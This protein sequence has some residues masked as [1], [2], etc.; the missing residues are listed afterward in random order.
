MLQFQQTCVN[1]DLV[2]GLVRETTFRACYT[3]N[4]CNGLCTICGMAV[5]DTSSHAN[6]LQSSC[7]THSVSIEGIIIT[8]TK[9][10]SMLQETLLQATCPPYCLWAVRIKI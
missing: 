2:R 3:L 7:H 1:C 9:H 5:R 8:C 10:C 6:I 4:G